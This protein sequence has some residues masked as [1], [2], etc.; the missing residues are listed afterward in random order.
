MPIQNGLLALISRRAAFALG[1]VA[2]AA[3]LFACSESGS[4]P[5]APPVDAAASIAITPSAP[6][7][8]L[9]AQL[10]L[11][12][13]VHDPE[14]RIMTGATVFWSSLDSTIATVAATGVVTGRAIGTTQVAAS[15]G[16]QS[17]VVP[18]AVVPAPVAS[19]AIAPAAANVTVGGTVVLKAVA[20][21][22]AGQ[23]IVGRPVVWASGAP[24]VAKIDTSGTATGLTA[25]VAVITATSGGQTA[26]A[27]VAVSLVPVATVAVTPGSA[28]LIVGH[29][30]S[31]SAVLTD[32][33][34]NVLSGRS[35][36][37]SVL[38]QS[39][40]TVTSL[41]LVTAV[42]PGTTSVHA[43]SE[44]K[45]GTAQI[46][47]SPAPPAPV[48]SVAISPSSTTLAI[49]TAA[50]LTVTLRDSVGATLTG[51]AVTWATSDP[52]VVTVSNVG[53]IIGM[54]AGTATIAASSEGKTGTATIAVQSP[55]LVPVATVR[56]SPATLSLR[57]GQTRTLT[58]QVL[59]AKGKQLTGRAIN[60]TSSDST[61]VT[62]KVTGPATATVTAAS[63]GLGTTIITA[64]C[65]GVSGSSV[66]TVVP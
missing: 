12:A 10:A 11:Q 56:L 47:V 8:I 49:G 16:G 59:D 39:I 63:R 62:L 25:G 6:A 7:V 28:A 61:V 37:W 17:A 38:D 50:A 66:V 9:G 33:R 18:V 42:G 26:S 45:T 5:L 15:S 24:Q 60:W 48:A 27:T 52:T 31:L 51:R 1:G 41:G 53:V 20:Y 23:A 55:Q 32:S 2:V 44:G 57:A 13:E 35:V 34:G 46:V 40:A 19:V 22:A 21:D 3:G 36:S 14:G 4:D 30:A 43:T 58:A 54:G 65:D 64:I 29:S